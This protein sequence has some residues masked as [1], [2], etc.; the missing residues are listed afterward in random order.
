MNTNRYS[1]PGGY[2]NTVSQ[3]LANALGYKR[4]NGFQGPQYSPNAPGIQIV[5]L[6]FSAA[7]ADNSTLIISDI[8][9]NGL[10]TT[11][12]FTYHWGGASGAGN[13]P[14]VAGGGTA[15]QAA[16]ATQVALAAQ[17]SARAWVVTN[18]TVNRVTFT[19]LI[20]GYNVAIP[21]GGNQATGIFAQN[22][23]TLGRT[24]P[25]SVGGRAVQ[26]PYSAPQS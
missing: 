10:L 4:N 5:T 18:T 2:L 23:A 14:L 1:L 26:L 25:A 9:A 21:F 22:A 12:N 11:V 24:L 19:G 16:T 8:D 20:P 7:P 15:A 13:I 6:T 17:L 3:L